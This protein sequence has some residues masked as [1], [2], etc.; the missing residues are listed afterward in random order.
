MSM[1]VS[2]LAKMESL[3]NKQIYVMPI[4]LILPKDLDKEKSFWEYFGMNKINLK[5]RFNL[6]RFQDSP[7]NHLGP[8]GSG[9][10]QITVSKF[11]GISRRAK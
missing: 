4:N 3:L 7:V 10:K 8:K 1:S 9:T 6:R 2:L 11:V 5:C